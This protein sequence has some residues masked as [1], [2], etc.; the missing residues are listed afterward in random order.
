[1]TKGGGGGV[2]CNRL[3]GKHYNKVHV[4]IR[5]TSKCNYK[6]DE[7]KTKDKASSPVVLGDFGYDVNCQACREN[8]PRTPPAIALDY[9]P[10]LVTRIART[11]LGKRLVRALELDLQVQA[12]PQTQALGP[13]ME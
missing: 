3:R 9:K 7:T 1:M 6:K 10:P 4:L 12:P 11:G 13:H 2:D 5:L 8:S